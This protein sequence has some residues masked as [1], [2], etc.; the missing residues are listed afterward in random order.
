MKINRKQSRGFTLVELL[1]VISII[2]LLA[3]VALPVFNSARLN[4]AMTTASMNA[5][6]I[7]KALT[8]YSSDNDGAFPTSDNNSN[9][10]F[11]ELFVY[12]YME[13]EKPFYVAGSAWHQ[14][15]RG[16][17]GP[18]DDI[19]TK[20]EYAQCLER[21]ENHWAYLS[22]LNTSSSS[23]MPVIA[24]GFTETPGSYT[25][26]PAKKGGVWKG[27]KAIIV[28][29]D[30]SAKQEKLDPRNGYKPMVIKGGQEVELFSSAYNDQYEDGNL[31]N[32][33]E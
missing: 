5:A 28:Y 21:G 32:P 27:Q 29:L 3:G 13:T 2:A 23:K 15:S 25:D 22:G 6:N 31:K 19:G 10:A 26:N 30:G 17:R 9:E 4:A 14:G 8:M 33:M 1:V 20:P 24:D 12:G 7:F 16:N 11:K 18:D